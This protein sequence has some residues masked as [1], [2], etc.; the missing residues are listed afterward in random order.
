[1]EQPMY[2]TF[3]SRTRRV[4]VEAKMKDCD[5]CGGTGLDKSPDLDGLSQRCPAGCDDGQVEIDPSEIDREETEPD[6]NAG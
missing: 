3:A 5:E 1:M 6:D 2:P 4:E